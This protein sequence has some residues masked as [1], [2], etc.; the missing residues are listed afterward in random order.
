MQRRGHPGGVSDEE[1]MKRAAN[2]IN[3]AVNNGLTEVLVGT[4]P[5]QVATDFGRA[6]NQLEPGWEN[7]LTGLPRELFERP[8]HGFGLPIDEWYRGALRGVLEKFTAAVR[9]KQR[10]LLDSD[11]VQRCV[12]FHVSGRRNFA[13]KL[14][15]IVDNVSS[16]RKMLRQVAEGTNTTVLG[17]G[18]V[19][20]ENEDPIIKGKRILVHLVIKGLENEGNPPDSALDR[21]GLKLGMAVEDS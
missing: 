17:A 14:H 15:A 13:R 21:D 4:F 11:E 1:R 10:G 3:R 6:I 8:K 20:C 19:K 18:E 12:Q 5:N 9:M 7:T 2:I 16:I